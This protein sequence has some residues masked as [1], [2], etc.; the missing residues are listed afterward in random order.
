[1]MCS[2]DESHRSLWIS[3]TLISRLLSNLRVAENLPD[4]VRDVQDLAATRVDDEQEA[5]VGH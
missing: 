1:M 4:G 2:F 3:A 5:G